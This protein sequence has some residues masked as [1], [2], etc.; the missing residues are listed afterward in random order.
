MEKAERDETTRKELEERFANKYDK[1]IWGVAEIKKE[2]DV[3]I[4][5]EE[6]ETTDDDN[7]ERGDNKPAAIKKEQDVTIKTE[8]GEASD[9]NTDN[10]NRIR[11]YIKGHRRA[12]PAL[13]F[14]MTRSTKMG[15]LF[16]SYAQRRGLELDSLR[17][18]VDGERIAESDTP[19]FLELED[20]D[21]I[22][23]PKA[24]S[25]C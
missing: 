25:A 7:T 18:M 17:F 19:S 14:E 23:A 1:E 20:G 5:T 15:K 8:E 16:Q 24:Q 12:D 13:G 4:K 3:V 9:D 21:Y 2:Q 6:G 10:H 22:D 11:I